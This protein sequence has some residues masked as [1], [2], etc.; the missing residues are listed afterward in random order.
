MSNIRY[1]ISKLSCSKSFYFKSEN[2]GKAIL[3]LKCPL[4]SKEMTRMIGATAGQW[5]ES[6]TTN[7]TLYYCEKH[8]VMNKP[9]DLK[10]KVDQMARKA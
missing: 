8:G 1:T 6:P 5:S 7:E 3:A 2:H 10:E 4:C 9:T